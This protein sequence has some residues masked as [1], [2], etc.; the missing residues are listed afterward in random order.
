MGWP[1]RE[2]GRASKVKEVLLLCLV[3][4]IE[5]HQVVVLEVRPER[6]PR[7]GARKARGS[8]SPVLYH[9]DVFDEA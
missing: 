7:K 5:M 4:V 9:E 2:Q 8:V 3:T 6:I 1:L